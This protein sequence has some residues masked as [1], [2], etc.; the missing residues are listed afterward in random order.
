[1]RS[2]LEP[3]GS[4]I[5][6]ALL[7]MIQHIFLLIFHIYILQFLVIKF[8]RYGYSYKKCPFHLPFKK[9]SNTSFYIPKISLKNLKI[10][11]KVLRN[12][13]LIKK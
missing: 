5:L 8:C 12:M 3:S 7:S 10:P 2:C 6:L 11:K 1:M 13:F 4:K 9:H